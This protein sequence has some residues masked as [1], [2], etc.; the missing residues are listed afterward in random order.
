M[1][2]RFYD[3]SDFLMRHYNELLCP[4]GN[5][6]PGQRQSINR[7]KRKQWMNKWKNNQEQT[8]SLSHDTTSVPNFKI[9]CEI[10]REKF[11]RKR[12]LH[13]HAHTHASTHART[14]THTHT[15]THG[16]PQ[17][18]TPLWHTV[19]AMCLIIHKCR[20]NDTTCLFY[21]F[22]IC[23]V[24]WKTFGDFWTPGQWCR[25]FWTL[26]KLMHE[27]KCNHSIGNDSARSHS[28]SSALLF[29]NGFTNLF[30]HYN[31]IFSNP[32]HSSQIVCFIT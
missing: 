26:G 14:H 17:N 6:Y 24:S 12:S 5:A 8:R 4:V 20:E 28:M 16:K 27:K 25:D 31:S 7:R 18:Y 23:L 13:T 11:D 29:T 32:N 3:I 30:Y 9:L 22:N 15:H 21:F 1:V 10:S 19:Y 2:R